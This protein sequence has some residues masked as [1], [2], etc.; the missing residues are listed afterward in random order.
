MLGGN[1]SD[2]EMRI[3]AAARGLCA[4]V[5]VTNGCDL[6]SSSIDKEAVKR[7]VSALAHQIVLTRLNAETSRAHL[8]LTALTRLLRSPVAFMVFFDLQNAV[9]M[10]NRIF[11]ELALYKGFCIRVTCFK[12]FG[13]ITGDTSDAVAIRSFGEFWRGGVSQHDQVPLPA[14]TNW[15][16]QSATAIML[17]FEIHC[18]RRSANTATNCFP[19]SVVKFSDCF[20]TSCVWC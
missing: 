2:G 15:Q 13:K 11:Q 4:N 8:L 9:V 1:G 19:Q 14:R 20:K 5:M 7:V 12:L 6:L 18:S 3:I 16:L 10:V 17:V